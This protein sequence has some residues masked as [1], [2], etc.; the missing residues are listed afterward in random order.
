MENDFV[1]ITERTAITLDQLMNFTITLYEAHCYT[2]VQLSR[3]FITKL[4]KELNAVPEKTEY[5]Q[6]Q[7]VRATNILETIEKSNANESKSWLDDERL[8]LLNGTIQL[9]VDLNALTKSNDTASET[10]IMKK[11]VDNAELQVLF[12]Y[13]DEL[14]KTTE[15]NYSAVLRQFFRFLGDEERKS[16]P[17]ITNLYDEYQTASLEGK[18]KIIL[19]LYEMFS[20]YKN[21]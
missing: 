12:N 15:R 16:F 17:I 18:F 9:F 6:R 21:K 2:Q 8:A 3:D 4:L 20:H 7:I 14:V 13:V 1:I 10:V 19:K 11:V 5:I